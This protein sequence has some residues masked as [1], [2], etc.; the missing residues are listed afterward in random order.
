[1][2]ELDKQSLHEAIEHLSDENLFSL[3][4]YIAFLRYRD[5]RVRGEAFADLSRLFEPIRNA[6]A[7]SGMTEDEINQVIQD[8]LHESR[9]G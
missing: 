4:E 9:H 3:R 1:M 8:S 5:A 6:A 2:S 7:Q